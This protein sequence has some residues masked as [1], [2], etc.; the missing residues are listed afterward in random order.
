MQFYL[1]LGALVSF[2]IKDR[3][4]KLVCTKKCKIK[5]SVRLA[6]FY[7]LFLFLS[8]YR[9]KRAVAARFGPVSCSITE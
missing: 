3:D 5:I 8:D 6:K 9:P 7:C 4:I 2:M 1:K